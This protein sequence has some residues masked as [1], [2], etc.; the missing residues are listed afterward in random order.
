MSI[1]QGITGNDLADGNVDASNNVQNHRRIYLVR[2]AESQ[3][4]V[5]KRD[6]FRAWQKWSRSIWDSPSRQEWHSISTLF[7]VPMDTDLSPAGEQMTHA[8]RNILQTSNFLQDNQI[9]LIVHSPLIRA[10]RTCLNVFEELVQNSGNTIPIIKHDDIFEKNISEH[11]G[12]ADMSQRT[13]NFIQWL[14]ERPEKN[15]VVVGH[16]A[17]FRDLLAASNEVNQVA[18]N[19]TSTTEELSNKLDSSNASN[20]SGQ[21]SKKNIAKMKNC[22]VRK[23]LLSEDKGFFHSSEIVVEGGMALLGEVENN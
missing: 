11:V 20:H 7:A 13:V 12:M 18:N 3:N 17:F 10:R 8:L 22:E 19:N 4:N 6:A 14:L 1:V 21:S 5:A 16:S 2:H 15:I 23:V 9:E